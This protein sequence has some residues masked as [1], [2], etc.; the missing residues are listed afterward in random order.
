M[1]G[2]LFS[3]SAF[4]AVWEVLLTD[5]DNN[6][7]SIDQSM[8]TVVQNK[9]GRNGATLS[10]WIKADFAGSNSGVSY[11]LAEIYLKCEEN[12][13]AINTSVQYDSNGRV[14]SSEYNM[15]NPSN[16]KSFQPVLPDSEGENIISAVCGP[17]PY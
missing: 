6:T 3:G 16:L 15:S 9:S 5:T 1:L 14:V 10:A 17:N 11:E 4:S 12:K 8:T 13:M 2:I 7:I